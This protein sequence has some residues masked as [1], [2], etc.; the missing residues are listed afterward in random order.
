MHKF[1]ILTFAKIAAVLILVIAT[2]GIVIAY[3]TQ[4][5]PLTS[6]TWDSIKGAILEGLVGLF[7][8]SL[9]LIIGYLANLIRYAIN[10]L[11]DL[12]R[13]YIANTQ[14]GEVLADLRDFCLKET[15]TIEAMA[16]KAL[17]NDNKID[18]AELQA[19]VAKVVED[20]MEV[21]GVKKIAYL[22][23]YRPQLKAWLKTKAEAI[24]R[25]LLEKFRFRQSEGDTV[26]SSPTQ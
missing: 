7:L 8:A 14:I 15:D 9:T 24:I 4:T 6:I 10:Y 18:N 2:S 19:I 26:I 13:T 22:E 16:V 17:E 5:S 11:Y 1:N 3:A 23:K 21:W 12:I 25:D 20:A